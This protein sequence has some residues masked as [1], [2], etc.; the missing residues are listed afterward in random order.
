MSLSLFTQ[1]L[2]LKL[3]VWS[4]QHS[5]GGSEYEEVKVTGLCSSNFNLKASGCGSE[6]DEGLCPP[7]YI[8]SKQPCEEGKDCGVCCVAATSCESWSGVSCNPCCAVRQCVDVL[9]C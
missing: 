3:P 2:G 8:N 7:G 4:L 5:A 1:C 6:D 9:L